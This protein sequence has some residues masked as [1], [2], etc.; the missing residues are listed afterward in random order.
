[1]DIIANWLSRLPACPQEDE[2]GRP[3]AMHKRTG[4]TPAQALYFAALPGA[5]KQESEFTMLCRNGAVDDNHLYFM[6]AGKLCR[7]ELTAI[8]HAGD[9][10]QLCLEHDLEAIWIL[11]GTKLS[12]RATREFVETAQDWDIKNAQYTLDKSQTDGQA[13]ATYLKAWKKKEARPPWAPGQKDYGRSVH[14]GWAEHNDKYGFYAITSPVTLLGA[15][16]YYED[17]IGAPA[18]FSAHSTGKN[19]MRAVNN[20]KERLPWLAPVDL[21]R[22]ACVTIA[23]QIVHIPC[24]PARDVVFMRPLTAQERAQGGYLVTADKNS[25][26]LAACT[27]VRLGAGDPVHKTHAQIDTSKLETGIYFIRIA[28]TSIFDG[29][30]LPHPT[31]GRLEGWFWVYTVKLLIDLGYEVEI[32]EGYTWAQSHTTLRPWAERLWPARASLKTDRA[33]YSNEPARLAAYGAMQTTIRGAIGLL[34]HPPDFTDRPGAFDWYRPDWNALI[35]DLARVKMFYVMWKYFKLG[36]IPFAIMT[37]CLYYIGASN[38]HAASLPGMF[39]RS[40]K[41]GGFK[42]KFARPVTTGQIAALQSNPRATIIE[43]N[44]SLLKYDRGEIEIQEIA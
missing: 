13:R 26:Y 5:G 35:V 40:D 33:R 36:F 43:V 8:D 25:M 24:L 44:N 39:D 17:A 27:D 30:L 29:D 28:G 1:M 38:D 32:V 6:Q 4:M 3:W 41:L 19:L 20:T 7:Q 2:Y 16:T 42:R 12:D 15:L 23:G 18:R 31:D 22:A 14:L 11:A 34:A 10:L 21:S 37:D 9:L